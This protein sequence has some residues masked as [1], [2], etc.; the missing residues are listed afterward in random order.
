MDALR[1]CACAGSAAVITVTFIHPID[2]VKTRMQVS[3]TAGARDYKSLG[4]FGTVS[5]VA[6]E[7]GVAAFWKGIPA[8]WLREASY[9]S[10]R[11]GL[12]APIKKA[13]GADQPGSGFFIKFAAGCMA[14]GIGSLAGNPFD[15]LKTKMMAAEGE[16]VSFA[17]TARSILKD[18]GAKG[19]Y[20]GIDANIAR[21][22][23]N[24]GT[25]MAC[26]DV[27]KKTIT[28]ATGLTGLPL[29]VMS[30]MTAGLAMTA[31]V[32]PFDMVRTR[33][34]NQPIVAAS[35]APGSAA[36]PLY[37]NFADCAVKVV[38]AQGMGALW[39]GAVPMWARIAPTTT[40]QLVL[41]E[42]ITKFAGQDSV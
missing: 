13:V 33:L 40:L 15:V 5:T 14:G 41:F 18:Q 4:L 25:K 16:G 12:Y 24:N 27:T 37:A 30:A 35:A 11:L 23:V 42:A 19:F 21:A 17:N 38:R 29:Q 34:M 20:K 31:T 3:G 36:A 8:A 28:G 32:A 39:A 7:E 6:S 22:M 10:L 1:S 26:Y 9:T 2:V